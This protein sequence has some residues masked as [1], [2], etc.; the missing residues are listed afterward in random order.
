M[1]DVLGT[2]G[3]KRFYE[4]VFQIWVEPEVQRRGDLSVADVTKA[5]VVMEPHTGTRVLLNEEVVFTDE[6]GTPT[7]ELEAA[8]FLRPAGL[9]ANAGWVGYLARG[10][11][12]I[13][14]FDFRRNR[15]RAS[16]RLDLAQEYVDTARLAADAGL[17][18]PAMWNAFAAAE[19]SVVAQLLMHN[20]E[21][22]RDHI[23]HR[24]LWR[25]WTDL[26]NAPKQ[27]S[28]TLAGLLKFRKAVRYG[29]GGVKLD[30][31]G[32][33]RTL[34]IVQNMVA[35]GRFRVGERH[36]QDAAGG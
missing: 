31:A 19:L 17:F 32:T 13:L 28:E 4:Q 11:E 12:A 2:E 3:G 25:Q 34:D 36:R 35:F 27:H 21:P 29:E 8:H 18:R 16:D 23:E 10:D 24:R 1:T 5:L 15:E 22:S 30:L 14:V 6:D 33:H 7:D 20:D 26:G 9:P